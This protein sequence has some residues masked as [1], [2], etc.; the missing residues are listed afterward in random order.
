MRRVQCNGTG[1]GDLNTQAHL[2]AIKALASFAVLYLI[3]FAV[4]ASHSVLVWD[5]QHTWTPVLYNVSAVYPSG[6]A[7]ILIL[8]NPKLKQAWVRMMHNLKCRLRKVPS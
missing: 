8:I 7:I 2:S 5:S 3:S 4:D 6:H 1:T